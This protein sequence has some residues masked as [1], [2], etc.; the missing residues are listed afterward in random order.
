M[1][2]VKEVKTSFVLRRLRQYRHFLLQTARIC[3]EGSNGLKQFVRL[4]LDGGSQ[5]SFVRR[6]VSLAV[7]CHSVGF[8]DLTIHTLGNKSARRTKYNSVQCTLHSQSSAHSVVI[9]A[10]E[11]EH[12]CSDGLPSVPSGIS[13]QLKRMG[14]QLADEPSAPSSVISVLIGS[15]HYWK[16]VTGNTLRLSKDLVAVETLFGWTVQGAFRFRPAN[17][18]EVMRIGV[19]TEEPDR[20]IDLQL[21]AFWEL[22]HLGIID[23]QQSNDTDGTVLQEFRATAK[24]CGGRYVVRLPRDP[25]KGSLL[26]DNKALA[27]QRLQR[28]TK[29]LLSDQAVMDE[30]DSTIRQYLTNDH[31]ERMA[32][33][34]VVSGPLYYM[35]HHA[36]I[37]RDRETTKVRIV[38][39]AS[40]KAPGCLSRNET[41]HAGPNLNPDVLELLLQFRAFRIAVTAD[42]EKAF[43][44]ILLEEADR[45]SLRFLWY[46]TTP[47]NGEPLPSVETWRMTRVPFGAKSSPFLLA[48]T[49]RHHLQSVETTYTPTASLLASHF[50]VDDLVVGLDTVEEALTLYHQARQILRAAS[51]KLVKWTSNCAPLRSTFEAD[52]TTSASDTSLKKVLGLVWDVD[53]DEL[54]YSLKSISEFL[55][56]RTDTK[57]CVL[58]TA[59]RVYDPLGYIAPFVITIKILLQRIWLSKIQW[60]DRLPEDLMGTWLSWCQEVPLIS[61]ISIPRT[62]SDSA[63]IAAASKTLHVFCDASPKAYGAVVYLV[64][65]RDKAHSEASLLLAKSRVAPV[66]HVSLPRLE[67]MGAVIAARLLRC[68]RATL[69]MP[70]VEAVLWTDSEV[71]LHWI[72]G[73][74][75]EWKPFVKNRVVDIQEI[76]D[77]RQWRHCPGC[78]NPADLLTRGINCLRLLDDVCWWHGP[79]WLSNRANWPPLWYQSDMI[80]DEVRM[81]AKPATVCCAPLTTH[82]PLLDITDF[83]SLHRLLRVTAWTKRFLHNCSHTDKREGAVSAEELAAAETYWIHIAQRQRF[84]AKPTNHKSLKSTSVFYDD[85]NIIRLK[86]RLQYGEFSEPLKYPIII[87]ADHHFTALLVSS[88]HVRLLHAGVQETLA[89]LRERYWVIRGRQVVRKVLHR[90]LVCRRERARACS[91]PTAPLPRD[92]VLPSP[93]FETVGTDYAGPLHFR[94]PEGDEAGRCYLLIFTCAITR[95]V[96]LELTK[97]M[98]AHDFLQAFQKFISR[99]GLPRTVY[100]DNF[101]TFKRA[102][103]DLSLAALS[104][105]PAVTG[106]LSSHRVTWKFIA[107]RAA[108]WGGFWERLIRSIKTCLRKILGRSTLDYDALGTVIVQ[109]EAVLNSRPLAYA[110]EDPDDIAVITPAHFLVGKRLTALPSIPS[111]GLSTG[112][113]STSEQLRRRWRYM[114]RMTD[115][116][117]SRWIK[118]YILYLR[119]AHIYKPLASDT[120]KIGDIV[121]VSNEKSRVLW[122]LARVQDVR[123]SGDGCIRS[124]RLKL[125]DGHTINRPIQLL[126]KLEA[127]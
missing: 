73:S 107:E 95:A 89:D 68:V 41:L 112:N 54:R 43:L 48:A 120:V 123:V 121:L 115:L 74:S 94:S 108:W 25:G 12:I 7:G 114:E 63:S 116:L 22:E 2:T 18:V 5:R 26:G 66:K 1:Y 61:R 49:I 57:R 36:V 8:E 46:S 10:I 109:L 86:G 92:R 42:V 113:E 70:E 50:Y 100:S 72:H 84:G 99:R 3:L 13:S 127:G 65:E 9:N 40:S 31:A 79:S 24:L 6:D 101:R 23:Q 80:V 76:T 119:S 37:R 11:Y 29:K 62:L 30:Y 105:H 103:R 78:D 104:Q 85:N 122:P 28:I 51:M 55:E 27:V 60:D 124:C 91:E 21:Q 14:L 38:F 96:H 39:D 88:T 56:K 59:S 35:P 19:Q 81:E 77:S 117:R 102:Q 111:Q 52:G 15:D 110:S 47:K 71:A 33:P 97:S 75:Q 98:T 20:Q 87:P 17:E 90:C 67:L 125:P 45:D 53:T 64:T 16:V 118:E 4:L 44:Q 58:Q 82:S 106:L 32:D 93:P 83:G 34:A 69:S 126:H